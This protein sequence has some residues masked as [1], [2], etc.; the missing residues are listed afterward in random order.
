MKARKIINRR[1]KFIY[2]L[3]DNSFIVKF[4]LE[5]SGKYSGIV[6]KNFNINSGFKVGYSSKEWS[7]YPKSKFWTTLPNTYEIS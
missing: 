5:P 2:A 7:Y 4:T 6:V 1:G 3:F